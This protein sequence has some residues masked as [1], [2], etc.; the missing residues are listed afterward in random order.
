[1]RKTIEIPR[2]RWAKYLDDLSNREQDHPVRIEVEGQELG[3]QAL[4]TKLPLMGIS[5]EEKGSEKDAIEITVADRGKGQTLTHLIERPEHVY[6]EQEGD[7]VRCVDI[8]NR[9]HVKTLIFFEDRRGAE[10]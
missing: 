1:M 4:S 10:T 6:V 8:E 7:R 3:D 2:E 5:L 9:A